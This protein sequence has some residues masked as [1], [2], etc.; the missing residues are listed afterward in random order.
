MSLWNPGET[1]DASIVVSTIHPR[2]MIDL[3]EPKV[4]K[5][6]YRRRIMGLKNTFGMM[7]VHALVPADRHPEIL[8]N[9]Y[10]I[11]ADENGVFQRPDL[12][13]IAFQRSAGAKPADPDH[14]RP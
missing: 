8:H 13:A 6:S 1:L 4:L 2:A 3:L 11:Q 5:P 12:P 9:L 14:L 10:S 7:A